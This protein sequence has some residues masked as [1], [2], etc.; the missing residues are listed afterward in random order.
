VLEAVSEFII[1]MR[2]MYVSA[3]DDGQAP[4]VI[5]AHD[6]GALVGFRLATEAPVLADRFILSNSVHVRLYSPIHLSYIN[7]LFFKPPLLQANIQNRVAVIGQMLRTWAH[8]PTNFRPLHHLFTHAKP[9]LR[10]LQKSGYI[11]AFG[12]PWPLP[13]ILSHIGNFW[14]FRILNAFG[15]S[16][17]PTAP[18]TGT[19]GWEILASSLGPSLEELNTELD[20]GN[21]LIDPLDPDEHIKY[22]ISVKSRASTGGW[23]EKLRL[24]R[25]NLV[26]SP[27]NKSLQLV[28]ELNQIEQFHA[29]IS[30]TS[31]NT[32]ASSAQKRRGS[33]ATFKSVGVFDIGPPGSLAAATTIIWG[34]K[35]VALNMALTMDGIGDYFGVGES[36]FV[37]LSQVGHW[38]P[39]S[40]MACGVWKAVIS[41]AV[42]GEE[43]PLKDKLGG[44]PIAEIK[45][46]S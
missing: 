27:W 18:L 29:S 16:N 43:G 40:S 8:N 30:S 7:M 35:D 10:Q 17:D 12:L 39:L 46:S 45:I 19:Q 15:E 1:K 22:P 4:V 20:I 32:T 28:W 5:V 41:W 2:E 26:A 44:F 34:N 31:T 38:T 36:H 9:L 24:Y 14:M 11:F 37:V 6:W 25:E 23:F 33:S 3:D 13:T 21:K 42:Q